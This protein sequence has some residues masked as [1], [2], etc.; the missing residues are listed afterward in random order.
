[1]LELLAIIFGI[2]LI[3]KGFFALAFNRAIYY[4]SAHY[5]K[6]QFKL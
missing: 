1:L 3:F 6:D 4:Y 2:I 5:F